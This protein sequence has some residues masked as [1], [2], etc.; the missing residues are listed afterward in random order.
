MPKN[1]NFDIPR[2]TR[3]GI[4]GRTG[5]GKSSIVESLL[6]MPEVEGDI[7]INGVN[8]ILV[9]RASWLS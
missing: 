9:P 7:I 8:I 3:I 2:E 4:V 5:D 1:V 6:R